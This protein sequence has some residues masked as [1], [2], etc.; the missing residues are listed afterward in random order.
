MK[1]LPLIKYS[2][3]WL[4]FSAIILIA[5]VVLLAV[6]GLKPG[7]DFT[8]GSLMEI[9]FSS[10]RPENTAIDEVL[11]TNN[12][13]NNV[14]QKSESR[15]VIIRTEF[16][17][18]KVHQKLLT[19][20]KSKLEADNNKIT[21]SRFETIG[22]VVSQQLRSRAIFAVFFVILGI[23]IYVAYAFRKV[24][25]PV[26]SWKY[27]LLAIVALIHD[28]ML[29]LGVFAVLGRYL[30]VEVN[31]AIVV[32]CL[33]VLGYSVNDTI[34][35]YDRIRENLLRTRWEDF[36]EVVNKGLNQTLLRSINTTLTTLLP[37]F[38]LYFLG[39]S[40]IQYFALALIIGIASGAYSS[41]FI[42]SPLLVLIQ[43]FKR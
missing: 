25:R 33:T 3:V 17:D 43:K 4:G 29:V 13:N 28:V 1:E 7:I 32:A 27:G 41:I 11:K 22:A 30:G 16:L 8:G 21:E 18:E 10:T 12:L 40:T 14:I 24:S 42:A 34:V 36:A 37:L 35:V 39:G 15:S 23:V 31:I 6:F 19:D 5:C 26:A 2:K 9:E 20:L 38:V